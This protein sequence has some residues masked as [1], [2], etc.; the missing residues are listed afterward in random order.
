[1]DGSSREVIHSGL[2]APYGLTMDYDLQILYWVDE[3]KLESSKPDGTN[4]MLLTESLQDPF[5]ITYYDGS[6]YWSDLTQH[7]IY[8][9]LVDSPSTASSIVYVGADPFDV[10]VVSEERQREGLLCVY[11]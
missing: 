11:K 5:G 9:S 1:M 7:R 6:L 4:R 8:S 3:N 2:T 10:K